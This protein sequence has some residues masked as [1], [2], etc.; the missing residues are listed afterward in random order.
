MVV[1]LLVG[2]A[3]T[4]LFT[5]PA[6]PPPPPTIP[7]PGWSWNEPAKLPQYSPKDAADAVARWLDHKAPGGSPADFP[8]RATALRSLLPRLPAETLPSLLTPLAASTARDD[9]DLLR[10]ACEIWSEQDPARAAAWVCALPDARQAA[11]LAGKILPALAETQASLALTLATSRDEAFAEAL[12][13]DV[14]TVLAKDDPAAVVLAHAPRFWNGGKGFPALRGALSAWTARDPDAALRWLV[15]Q[16]R[17]YDSYL[18]AWLSQ[19]A[20]ETDRAALATALLSVPDLPDRRTYLVNRLY[21]WNTRSSD[22]VLAWLNTVPDRHLRTVLLEGVTN[23]T[24]LG[25]SKRTLPLAL[26][27]PKGAIRT[28]RLAQILKDWAEEDAPAALAWMSAHDDPDVTAAAPQV[29]TAILGSIASKDP[30]A[31]VEQWNTLPEGAAKIAAIESIVDAWSRN[32]PDQALQ[33]L[34]KVDGAGQTHVSR[35]QLIYDWAQKDPLAALRWAETQPDL[36]MR[37]YYLAAISGRWRGAENYSATADLYAHIKD[38][39]T[40]TSILQNHVIE[41]RTKDPA[42]AKAWVEKTPALTPEQ[43]ARLLQKQ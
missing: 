16:P 4:W 14:L 1:G 42:G 18:E 9:R 15:A 19:L 11:G 2:A 43:A 34:L 31:A 30:Q 32:A 29:R 23:M 26:A 33:W 20:D 12:L 24:T 13:S 36:N 37:L 17:P 21:V 5:R 35:Q 22:E 27:M 41:W 7:L 8:A 10:I 6:P 39:D 28:E 3:G 25:D 40:R 38:A